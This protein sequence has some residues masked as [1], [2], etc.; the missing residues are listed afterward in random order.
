VSASHLPSAT[1]AVAAAAEIPLPSSATHCN[2]LHQTATHCKTPGAA[3]DLPASAPAPAEAGTAAEAAAEVRGRNEEAVGEEGS[4][5]AAVAKDLLAYHA[6][7]MVCVHEKDEERC[8][9]QQHALS[10]TA[11]V[12]PPPA[13]ADG[14]AR[15]ASHKRERGPEVPSAREQVGAGWCGV[16][17]DGAHAQRARGG[18]E[19]D[20]EIFW[21][22]DEEGSWDNTSSDSTSESCSQEGGDAGYVSESEERDEECEVQELGMVSRSCISGCASAE[23]LE[24]GMGSRSGM[25]EGLRGCGGGGGTHPGCAPAETVRSLQTRPLTSCLV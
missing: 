25:Q 7:S 2:A 19:R 12:A 15:A 4:E 14:H 22:D 20:R 11:H 10:A 5:E 23:V 17:G 21:S 18:G 24:L 1:S 3:A 8:I 6:D 16:G 9:V 13:D